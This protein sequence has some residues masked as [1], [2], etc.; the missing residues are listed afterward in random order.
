VCLESGFDAVEGCRA[1]TH[2]LRKTANKYALDL[3]VPQVRLKSGLIKRG[4]LIPIAAI[5]LGEHNR[6]IRQIQ[7]VVESRSWCP[8]HTVHR[9]GPSRR[10]KAEMI[11]RM[12]VS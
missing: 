8:L 1:R 11:Q 3:A 5:S 12:P 9:P 4:V 10:R 2:V 6:T 7:L